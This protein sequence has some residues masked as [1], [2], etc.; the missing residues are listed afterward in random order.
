MGQDGSLKVVET[1]E[2]YYIDRIYNIDNEILEL[3][4]FF[5]QWIY[6]EG[7]PVYMM[8]EV[9]L[10]MMEL[11]RYTDRYKYYDRLFDWIDSQKY[12]HTITLIKQ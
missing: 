1:G 11:Y 5:D 10:S 3:Y 9:V 7:I 4:R 12:N 8:K 2:S 6:K